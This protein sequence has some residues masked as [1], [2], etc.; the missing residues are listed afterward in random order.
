MQQEKE[1]AGR[2][3]KAA[4]TDEWHR[5]MI[6]RRVREAKA[7]REIGEAPTRRKVEGYRTR[8]IAQ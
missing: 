4:A 2:H 5:E 1:K 8:G 6:E 3:E 7:S